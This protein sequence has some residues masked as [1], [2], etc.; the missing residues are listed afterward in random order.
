M[1]T[2]HMYKN[3]LAHFGIHGQKWGI[4][5][6]QNEDRTWTE[7]GK[8]RYGKKSERQIRKAER[9]A[10][11]KARKDAV[12][13]IRKNNKNR[14]VLSDD[15][16]AAA[17]RRLQNEKMLRELTEREVNAGRTYA[18][19]ILKDV[20]KRTIPAIATVGAL[21]AGKKAISHIT[22]GKHGAELASDIYK[23]AIKK[24]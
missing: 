20:G 14:Q 19:E 15:E 8:K 1:Y 4:R 10:E 12:K 23:Y 7:E 18:K 9:K 24:K 21:Y 22:K 2:E 16:L 17:V 6:F 13:K 3:S 11:K 5:R